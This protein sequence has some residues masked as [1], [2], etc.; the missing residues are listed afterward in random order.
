MSQSDDYRDDDLPPPKPG[1]SGLKILLIILGVV[2]L[3]GLLCVGG[4]V[5]LMFWG[6]SS[7]RQTASSLKSQNNMKQI[8]L[9]MHNYND[10]HQKLPAASL[11][12]KDGKPGLSWRVALL[13]Y[14]EQGNLHKQFKLDEPW[15]SPNNIKLL[16]Q[17]PNT[18]A[19]PGE[20]GGTTTHYRVFVGNGAMFDHDKSLFFTDITDGTSNT[21]AF[22]EATNAVPWTKPEELDYNPNGDLPPLGLPDRKGILVA[23][24]DGAVY[25]VSRNVGPSHW[26]RAIQYRDGQKPGDE[27]FNL[28][29]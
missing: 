26:H 10:D 16:N 28:K 14:I 2:G 24:A 13:P 4:A 29:R 22:V 12:T 19:S 5:G 7:I 17:M 18:Y 21:V 1:G 15:D 20:E 6:V 27:F 11:K 25:V 9:A 23:M 3:F 8:V